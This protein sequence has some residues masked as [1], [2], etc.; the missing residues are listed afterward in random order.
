MQ[1]QRPVVKRRVD[2]VEVAL[3]VKGF[4]RI[5]DFF[6][7]QRFIRFLHQQLIRDA[8]GDMDQPLILYAFNGVGSD[9]ERRSREKYRYQHPP[10]FHQNPICKSILEVRILP[11]LRL[12]GRKRPL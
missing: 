1:R 4:D 10:F 6:Q 12:I 11:V 9:K 5:V 8:F 7:I 3:L 2:V